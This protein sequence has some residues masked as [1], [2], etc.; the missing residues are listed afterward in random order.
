MMEGA[1]STAGKVADVATPAAGATVSGATMFGF[2]VPELIQYA[3]LILVLLQI[4]W[5]V[6]KLTMTAKGRNDDSNNQ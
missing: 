5:W 1:R 3:T 4:V 6:Y 2:N